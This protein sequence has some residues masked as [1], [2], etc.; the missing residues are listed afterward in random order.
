[1]AWWVG[2]E[3]ALSSESMRLS[4]HIS[5]RDVAHPADA[6][7]DDVNEHGRVRIDGALAG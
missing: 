7:R 1:V 4:S 2:V 5:N 3:H 6:E